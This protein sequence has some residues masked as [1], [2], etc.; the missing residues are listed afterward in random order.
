MPSDDEQPAHL[1]IEEWLLAQNIEWLRKLHAQGD[2]N[3]RLKQITLAVLFV[4]FIL[5]VALMWQVQQRNRQLDELDG[6]TTRIEDIAEE[7]QTDSGPD[8]AV[9]R[10]LRQ[11]DALCARV[12][13][14]KEE[15]P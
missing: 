1:T 5:V 13:C 14:D 3:H 12:Q 4:V 9:A 6:T 8:P 10:G 11:I 7:F 2:R 15:S